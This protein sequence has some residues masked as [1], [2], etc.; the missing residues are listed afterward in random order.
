MRMRVKAKR[1]TN[2]DQTTGMNQKSSNC[3]LESK[4]MLDPD[5]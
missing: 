4:N 1:K 2:W 3:V 5:K